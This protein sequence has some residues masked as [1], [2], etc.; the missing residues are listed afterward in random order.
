MAET[1]V[2]KSTSYFKISDYR[3]SFMFRICSREKFVQQKTVQHCHCRSVGFL[4]SLRSLI[5]IGGLLPRLEILSGGPK[6]L[7]GKER[8]I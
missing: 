1:S 7:L 6:G 2:K 4:G 3:L 8:L 5:L